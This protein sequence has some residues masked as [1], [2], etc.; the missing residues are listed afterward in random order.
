MPLVSSSKSGF[1]V[2]LSFA[3]RIKPVSS[4]VSLIEAT[5]NAL[6]VLALLDTASLFIIFLFKDELSDI[7]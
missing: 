4:T 5:A 6:A 7:V 1:S 3:P 2:F